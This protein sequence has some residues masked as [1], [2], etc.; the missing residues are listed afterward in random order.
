[1]KGLHRGLPRVIA[2][3]LESSAKEI[4]FLEA[5]HWT[6]MWRKRGES[7]PLSP[8]HSGYNYGYRITI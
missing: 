8:E 2:F 5:G 6:S 4:A 1:M 3:A 7:V